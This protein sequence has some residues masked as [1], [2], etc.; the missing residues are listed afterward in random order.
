MNKPKKKYTATNTKNKI[1]KKHIE[2]V[3]LCCKKTRMNK[4]AEKGKHENEKKKKEPFDHQGL[5]CALYLKKRQLFY[6]F[7]QMGSTPGG[8]GCGG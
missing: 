2:R 1:E 4:T 8:G 5:G 6:I 3:G 7:H